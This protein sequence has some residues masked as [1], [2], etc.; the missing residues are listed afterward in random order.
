MQENAQC[1]RWSPISST[2]DSQ[3]DREQ[4][5][6]CGRLRMGVWSYS[7]PR[8]SPSKTGATP[9]PIQTPIPLP[10]P[11]EGPRSD[12]NSPESF[13]MDVP[14]KARGAKW[15]RGR[16]ERSRLLSRG[17]QGHP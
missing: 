16:R 4:A 2:R 8:P 5:M 9:L 13:A 17:T 14:I 10:S 7:R 3:V 1:V 15:R 11:P 12:G 6:E